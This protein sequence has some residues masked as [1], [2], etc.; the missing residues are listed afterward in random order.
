MA[1]T[2]PVALPH[3]ADVGAPPTY[4]Q[5]DRTLRMKIVDACGLNCTF[6]HNEG[7]PVV[8]DNLGRPADERTAAGPSGRVSIYLMTNGA[9]FLPATVMPDAELR[10]TLRALRMA[11]DLDELHLTGGEPTLHPRLPELVRL[12][13]DAGFRVC[14]TSNGENGAR[15]LP[16][17][18]RAGLDRV[19]FSVF[20]TTGAE[21][22][23]VQQGRSAD[24][25]WA[26]RKIQ[27]L[28]Q[29]IRIALAAGI[30]ASAN[31]V[32]PGYDHA[33]R[34]RR[35]LAEHTP[36]LSVRLLNSLG[37]GDASIRA[38]EAIL[39]D[40]DAV[41]IARYL[42]AGSSGARTAY[43]LPE[44]RVVLFKQIRAVRLPVTC[45][46]CRFNNATDCQEG[47]YGVRLY[48][49]RS[50]GY[51]IGVCVQRMDLCQPVGEFLRG[52]LCREILALRDS[53]YGQQ[54]TV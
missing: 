21:L 31:I 52:D 33:P 18:G 7:T 41:P 14:L 35:L 49:D 9:R 37:E 25:E 24:T 13:R 51:Q 26:D 10:G 12:G 40:L 20:G 1:A 5:R 23:Q 43:R 36:D 27:A 11:L 2:T 44:G 6:C 28:R 53:E 16:A 48:R 50:G 15:M 29:S 42:T 8:R 46:G 19:N 4:L 39:A 32:V 3:I 22:V 34:V 38:I 47:F 54:S 30:R 17:C 45:T